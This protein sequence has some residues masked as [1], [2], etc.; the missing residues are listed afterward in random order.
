MFNFFK[1]KDQ[2]REQAWHKA[3][4]PVMLKYLSRAFPSPK[5]QWDQIEIVSLD[6]ETTGLN[7]N[8]HQILSYGKV[9]IQQGRINLS[10]AKHELVRQDSLIPEESAVIHH[11]TDDDVSNARP[12][13]EVLPEL[14][15]DLGGKVMLV[16]YKKIEQGFL[17]AACQ[18]LYGSPFIIP[19]I[20][21]LFLSQRVLEKRNHSLEPN[22]LRLFNLRDSFYLPAYKA[23]NALNDAMTTAELFL[24]L[25][26]EISPNSS[27]PLKRLLA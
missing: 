8:H 17:N 26:G 14:L 18:K 9:H 20:D 24:M 22:Q 5:T 2:L 27:T 25:E 19:T 6:F 16:H 10:T 11:I 15:H 21:T 1:S 7:P 13:E 3:T 23:H 12:I 4:H